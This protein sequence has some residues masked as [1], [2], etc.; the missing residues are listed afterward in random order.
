MS[1]TSR[2]VAAC[3]PL[4]RLGD[5]NYHG[6]GGYAQPKENFKHPEPWSSA[7]SWVCKTIE[8][9]VSSLVRSRNLGLVQ[10]NAFR[11]IR[12]SVCRK[13]LLTISPG[14]CFTR[15]IP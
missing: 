11:S 3:W 12:P 13:L 2:Q 5:K 8:T 15:S 4:V 10:L 1:P 6:C 9:V 14:S 7:F